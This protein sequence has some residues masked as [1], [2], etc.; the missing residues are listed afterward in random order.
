ML[1]P[2][3]S[4]NSASARTR[5][6]YLLQYKQSRGEQSIGPKLL[7]VAVVLP[8]PVGTSTDGRMPDR[9]LT[10]PEALERAFGAYNSGNLLEAERLCTAILAV[11]EDCFD[12]LHLLAVA[13]ARLGRVNA[14]VESF[15]RALAVR[16]N[17]ADVLHNCGLALHGLA[18]FEE[19]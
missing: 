11:N 4:N 6:G 8:H 1:W 15:E 7:T 14:A 9:R 5:D 3:W 12:A 13:Q 16:P 19:A 2:R 10:L 18:R 17:D